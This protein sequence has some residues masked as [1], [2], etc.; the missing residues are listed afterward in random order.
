MIQYRRTRA[1]DRIQ[2][3]E[4]LSEN[5]LDFDGREPMVGF[6]ADGD[7]KLVGVSFAHKA[8]VID[9]FISSEPIAAIKLFYM[10]EGA[11]S[12]EGYNTI[13]V[14]VNDMNKKLI[15]ELRRVGFAKIDNGFGIFK[16][17]L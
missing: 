2:I 16:K 15:S 4:M 9:P 3:K 8:A 1:A 12:V 5:H 10:T 6:V 11:L 13:I 17:V 7:D 14:Q